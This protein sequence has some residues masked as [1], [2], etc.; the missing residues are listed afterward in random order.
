M[1]DTTDLNQLAISK[2]VDLYF[3]GTY[4]GDPEQLKQAFHPDAYITGNFNGQI[5]N[6]SLNE[7]ITRVTTKPTAAEKK[8]E[9]NKKIIFLDQT[10][11]AAVVKAQVVVNGFTF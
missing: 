3:L 1:M 7:F 10:G 6:W 2:I 8:E 9:Y 4:H 11:D 5:C